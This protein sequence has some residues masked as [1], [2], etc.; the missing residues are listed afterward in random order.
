MLEH[1][2]RAG[3]CTRSAT[4]CARSVV[5]SDCRGDVAVG[6]AAFTLIE[7]LV[8][9]AIISILA[10]LLL[11]AL[12]KAKGRARIAECQN[13]LRQLY[14][15]AMAFAT[16]NNDYLPAMDLTGALTGRTGWTGVDARGAPVNSPEDIDRYFSY[17]YGVHY[18][19]QGPLAT[20]SIYFCTEYRRHWPPPSY[21][22]FQAFGYAMNTKY[23]AVA[24]G[25]GPVGCT[26]W[27]A[28][29]DNI[30]AGDR[31]ASIAKPGFTV[32]MREHYPPVTLDGFVSGTDLWVLN[33]ATGAPTVFDKFSRIHLDG[34]NVLY[35]DG[36]VE[37][38][39]WPGPVK[40]QIIPGYDH[41]TY[42]TYPGCSWMW[43]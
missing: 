2:H 38:F 9:V 30:Q 15:G 39:R 37:Y 6:F 22:G 16:E 28:A 32:Y 43:P 27:W 17:K 20:P 4:R 26:T 24:A 7:L 31:L 12:Q 5:G 33:P 11:P 3:D 25:Q 34:Q 1:E 36:H 21:I 40:C 42:S 13:N 10:A 29:P 18:D 19:G 14:I 23:F 41:T 8:V 35:F